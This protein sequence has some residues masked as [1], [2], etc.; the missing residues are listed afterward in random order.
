ML[1]SVRRYPEHM[2]LIHSIRRR[3]VVLAVYHPHKPGRRVPGGAAVEGE[4]GAT[5]V[6]QVGEH[7]LAYLLCP[8]LAIGQLLKPGSAE[9]PERYGPLDDDRRHR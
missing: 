1:G 9:G 7:E 3:G 5:V 8:V 6:A 2:I 4:D